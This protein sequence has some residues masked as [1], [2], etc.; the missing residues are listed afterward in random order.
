[1]NKEHWFD[2]DDDEQKPIRPA[3]PARGRR[4]HRN[5]RPD[6]TKKPPVKSDADHYERCVKRGYFKKF[7]KRRGRRLERHSGIDK[8]RGRDPRHLPW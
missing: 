3:K 5:I 1:M 2:D 4:Q 8:R 7:G 6:F